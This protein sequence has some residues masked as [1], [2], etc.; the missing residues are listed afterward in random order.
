MVN[1]Q[2]ECAK[3]MKM[4]DTVICVNIYNPFRLWNYSKQLNDSSSVNNHLALRVKNSYKYLVI[5]Q[6]NASHC[7]THEVVNVAI[8]FFSENI[9]K[10]FT[11]PTKFSQIFSTFGLE[12][13]SIKLIFE[14]WILKNMLYKSICTNHYVSILKSVYL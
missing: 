7:W 2:C 10:Q 8:Q 11:P 1:A 4:L 6:N 3:N 12:V 13:L 9:A 14:S 5:Y